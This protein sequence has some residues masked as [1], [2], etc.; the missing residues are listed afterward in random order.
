[1]ILKQRSA[2]PEIFQLESLIRRT[3]IVHP[4]ST[5]WTEK[6]RRISAGFHGEQHVDSLWHEIPI[7]CPHYFLHDLFVQREK[8]SHQMDT[9]LV[10]NR[11]VLLMEIKSIAGQLD[12]DPQLRQF[13]RTNKDGTID[14]MRNPDDQI[15]RHEKWV[16][17]FLADKKISLPVIG[18]IVFTYPSSIVNNRPKNRIIIQASGLPFLMDQFAIK[19]PND[20][21]NTRQTRRLADHFLQLHT[22]RPLRKLDVPMDLRRGVLCGRDCGGKMEYYWRKW[23]CEK[24]FRVDRLAHFET[25]L[26]YR[27]LVSQ[28][29]SNKEFREFTGIE[30]TTTA[31]KLLKMANMPFEGSYKDRIYQI[32][33]EIIQLESISSNLESI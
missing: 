22:E 16:R 18:I 23:T 20:V 10:T 14:G 26:Q 4:L 13:S 1:M 12:F 29:I 3:P 28:T 19:Y 8:S 11:Y 25:L 32:P 2:P 9:V 27:V 33:H 15:L 7:E 21:L 31:S 30:S 24:C 17:R 6:L 5:H